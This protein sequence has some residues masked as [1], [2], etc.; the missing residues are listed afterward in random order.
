MLLHQRLMTWSLVMPWGCQS[1]C[2]EDLPPPQRRKPTGSLSSLSQV[3]S[4]QISK[5][6]GSPGW[7]HA[8][9]CGGEAGRPG[10]APGRL[11]QPLSPM[12][13]CAW[14]N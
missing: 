2:P 1:F 10:G 4:W 14:C 3:L 8:A 6:T 7:E 5:L 9:M 12:G 11:Q 13:L